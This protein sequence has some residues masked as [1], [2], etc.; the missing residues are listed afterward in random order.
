M[1]FAKY[2]GLLRRGYLFAF[3]GFVSVHCY[4]ALVSHSFPW[5]FY[6]FTSTSIRGL[7]RTSVRSARRRL[8][9]LVT[10]S[11]IASVCIPANWR[12]TR[13]W[14][15]GTSSNCDKRR[16]ML[17]TGLTRMQLLN[18]TEF[19]NIMIFLDAFSIYFL[20]TTSYLILK[21]L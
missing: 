10:A 13:R 21:I 1:K 7:A 11:L 5:L 18:F 4:C 20:F 3:S 9:A 16:I 6:S 14:Q 17:H 19:P 2:A 15:T 12:D 8:P